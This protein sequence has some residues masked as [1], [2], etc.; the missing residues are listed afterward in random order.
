MKRLNKLI[1]VILLSLIILPFSVKASGSISVS[2]KNISLAPNGSTS[3]SITANNAVGRINI[4]SSNTGVATVSAGSI[5]VENNTQTITVKAGAVGTA[6]INV[7]YSDVAS[8]DEEKITGGT[9]ITVTVKAPTNNNNNN[10]NNNNTTKPTNPVTNNKNNKSANN[11]LKK[12]EVSGYKLV[13]KSNNSYSVTVKNSVD[14]IKIIAEAA[15]SKASVSGAGEKTLKVGDNVFQVVCTAENGSKKTYTITVTRKDDTYYLSDL[16]DAIS[17]SKENIVITLKDNDILTSEQLQKIKKTNKNAY[18]IMKKDSK[19]LYSWMIN[20]K[21]INNQDNIK[22]DLSF[23]ASNKNQLEKLTD[24][25]EGVYLNFSH[26]GD[27]PKNTILRIYVGDKYT[28]GDNLHLYFLDGNENKITF[29]NQDVEVTNGYVEI[30]ID[31]CSDYFLTKATISGENVAVASNDTN[32][33]PLIVIV[34]LLLL[35]ISVVIA[36]I[37]KN[38]SKNETVIVEDT[39]KDNNNNNNIDNSEMID[40]T[41]S[42]S[43]DK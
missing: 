14:K 2:T 3:F 37:I 6:T 43:N 29:M 32:I 21:N 5:W 36:I 10:N 23:T 16:D 12:I 13:S 8:F 34:I 26:S 40:T 1:L 25:R 24:Y 20:S 28:D 42:Y 35:I 39:N 11:N 31:H 4:S 27:L 18:F 22:L 33:I 38:G 19:T 15:D 9:T 30:S 7:V 17:E 41:I